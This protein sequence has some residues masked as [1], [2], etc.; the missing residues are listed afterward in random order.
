MGCQAVR[1]PLGSDVPGRELRASGVGLRGAWDVERVPSGR[2]QL[3]AAAS[4]SPATTAP[5]TSATLPQPRSARHPALQI[6][7]DSGRRAK[8]RLRA[9]GTT[10]CTGDGNALGVEHL[11]QVATELRKH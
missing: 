5:R 3:W 8:L 4:A 11:S 1:W 9:D 6:G 2:G 7:S 10:Y